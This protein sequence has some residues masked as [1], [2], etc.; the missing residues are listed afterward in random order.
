M[1]NV[2]NKDGGINSAIDTKRYRSKTETMGPAVKSWDVVPSDT[3]DFEQAAT[4]IYCGTGGVVACVMDD[5]SVQN[6]TVPDGGR[7][8]AHV[9]RVNNTD[10]T[11][12]LMKATV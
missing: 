2:A 7:V 12:D 1:A 8:A 10:T 5:R 6:F 9:V 3:V 11:A 4:E